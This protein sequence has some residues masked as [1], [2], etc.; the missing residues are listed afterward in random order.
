MNRYANFGQMLKS[1]RI[2][3]NKTL[4]QCANDL[5]A[6][7]SNW[8]K[9]ERGITPAPKDKNVLIRWAEYLEVSQA[10]QPQFLDLAALS[11]QEIP[12]DIANDAR[13]IAA[14]PAF[15]RAVRGR[16]LEG[17]LLKEFIDD[18][19]TVHSPDRDKE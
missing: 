5:D 12:Q 7:P 17:D 11:R 14:L 4:R 8:S 16:E 18:L 1:V 2:A 9:L 19:R 10:E 3:L 13:V 6:D 15:F